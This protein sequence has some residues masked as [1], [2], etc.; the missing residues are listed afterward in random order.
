M[1]PRFSPVKLTLVFVCLIIRAESSPDK[2]IILD[3]ADITTDYDIDSQSSVHLEA[4]KSSTNDAIIQSKDQAL[5]GQLIWFSIGHPQIVPVL[6]NTTNNKQSEYFNFNTEGFYFHVELLNKDYRNALVEVIKEKYNVVVQ[7]KQI[8]HFVPSNFNCALEFYSNEEKILINGKV[9]EFFKFPLRI[10]FK[11]P[12]Q[13]KER[14]LLEKRIEKDGNKLDLNFKCQLNSQ[15]KIIQKGAFKITLSQLTQYGLVEDIFGSSNIYTY[16]TRDQ[17]KRLSS[18]IYFLFD[19]M[20]DY[21]MSDTEFRESFLDDFLKQT[22]VNIDKYVDFDDTLLRSLSPYSAKK[23]LT[24][25]EF[26]IFTVK[27]NG[28]K[29]QQIFLTNDANNKYA[30]VISSDAVNFVVQNNQ[31][32]SNVSLDEQLN[33]LNNLEKSDIKWQI[34]AGVA[35]MPKS[36][37]VTRLS[38]S[39]FARDLTFNKVK[40]DHTESLFKR[41][42]IL[43][44]LSPKEQANIETGN[45]SKLQLL[46]L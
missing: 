35:I 3:A 36:I 9:N 39:L 20:R 38:R 29:K 16:I 14:N 30:S 1:L 21:Q 25:G 23:E 15:S 12:A 43:E 33:E 6:K 17:L 45:Q 31:R 28:T 26:N 46:G 4:F 24:L 34:V 11:A 8:V 2:S 5:Y 32:W 22:S 13:T 41:E 40:K 44:T 10:D 37:R 27:F 19:I 18:Q 42:F 7:P